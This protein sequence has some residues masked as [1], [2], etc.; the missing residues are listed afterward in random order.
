[1]NVMV[2][3]VPINCQHLCNIRGAIYVALLIIKLWQLS[4][5]FTTVTF[6][7]LLCLPHTRM[8]NKHVLFEQV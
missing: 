7:N 2:D 8:L 6:A 3:L 4:T 1:M 5:P